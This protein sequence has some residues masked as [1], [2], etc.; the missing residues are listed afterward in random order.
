MQKVG[1][2]GLGS[3]GKIH[4]R[5]YCEMPECQ[6]VGVMD[7]AQSNLDEAKARFGVAG[8]S[9]LEDLLALELDAVSISVPTV[10]HHEVGMAVIERGVALLLEKPLAATAA[11]GAELVRAARA[12]GV[13]LMVGH[14]ERFNPAV[15]RV[16]ELV[17]DGL[18]SLEI[19]R[20]GPFPARIQDVGVIR[21][22]GSHDIDLLRYLTGSDF[23]SVSGVFSTS[24]GKHEDSAF[25]CAQMENGVLGHIK[26]N[27]LTPQRSRKIRAACRDR[28]IEADLITQVVREL[29]PFDA[30]SKTY[31]VR[32][33]PCV[34]REQMREELTQFLRCVREKTP[35]PI[36]GEDGLVV[37][38]AIEQILGESGAK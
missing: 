26:T 31:S 13:P 36:S 7:V 9:R 15:Q 28:F 14:I 21:D 5:N 32:E 4:L 25:I 29:S 34:Y 37:L 12:K 33:W 10:L 35:V 11:Q 23:K 19:E 24:Q 3:M 18:V 1:V 30:V 27:W 8:F 2:I 17:A 6:V 38:Q 20:V 22:L 16:K